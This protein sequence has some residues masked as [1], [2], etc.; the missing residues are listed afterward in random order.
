MGDALRRQGKDAG[1]PERT[2][3]TDGTLGF[4]APGWGS[5]ELKS[6]AEEEQTLAAAPAGSFCGSVPLTLDM[7]GKAAGHSTLHAQALERRRHA[8]SGKG[9]GTAPAKGCG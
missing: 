3:T 8:G 2:S 5:M 6:Q 1:Q 4:L 9:R 7:S